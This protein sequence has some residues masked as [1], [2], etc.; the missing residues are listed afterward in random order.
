MDRVIHNKDIFTQICLFAYENTGYLERIAN[1]FRDYI[2]YDYVEQ[3]IKNTHTLLYGQVQSGKT[4]KLIQ[5]VKKVR[6]ESLKIITIQ[7]NLMMLSQYK[8]ALSANN[9]QYIETCNINA[10]SAYNGESAILVMNNKYRKRAITQYLKQNNIQ[11]YSMVMDESDMYYEKNKE[12][13]LFKNAKYFLHIT[14]TPFNYKLKFDSILSIPTKKN[15]VGINEVELV[16]I[17]QPD[18]ATMHNILPTK[19]NLIIGV[20]KD[21]FMQKPTGFMLINCFTLIS[22]MHQAANIIAAKY[23][24]IPVAVISSKTTLWYNSKVKTRKTNNIQKYIDQFDMN[25][26]IIIIAN[27]YSNRGINYCNSKYDRNITHQISSSNRNTKFTNYI[28]K[29]RIFGNR[30]DQDNGNM[31]KPILYNISKNATY[32]YKLKNYINNGITNLKLQN[33]NWDKPPHPLSKYSVLELKNIC[34][35]NHI[36]GYS[37]KRKEQII[38]LISSH[39]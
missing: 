25:S 24:N 6:P 8:R 16:H 28:Q 15:Y 11:N 35:Q 33:E 3:F 36:R 10:C 1:E 32:L 14:A 22:D 34:K 39:M 31:Y 38:N 7:N 13:E 5:Y 2:H 21:D 27:R 4:D 29:C 18:V 23:S 26:H 17:E 20:I 19:I 9:I 30:Q 37:G 12:T